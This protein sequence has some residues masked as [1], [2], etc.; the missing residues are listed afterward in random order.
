MSGLHALVTDSVI[1]ADTWGIPSK[2]FL[3]GYLVT[4]VIAI[5]AS[6]VL[7]RVYARSLARPNAQGAGLTA[8]E[9]GMLLDEK[10][11]VV[12]A[13]AVLRSADLI[14][15]TGHAT[16][17]LGSAD[18]HIDA[19]T[20]TVHDRIS[21]AGPQSVAAL[22]ASLTV[23]LAQ[24]RTSM[25]DRGL[26]VGPEYRQAM[27]MAAVPIAIVAVAGIARIVAGI[28]NG[29]SV[30][31]LIAIVVVLVLVGWLVS[32]SGRRTRRGIVEV[33]SAVG[34][35]RSS[36]SRSN[37]RL[38]PGLAAAVTGGAALWLLD[39]ALAGASGVSSS[40]SGGMWSSF[41]SGGDGG[42]S[43]SSDSGSGSSCGGGSSGCGGGGGGCG[44]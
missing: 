44:G 40:D 29:K 7:R 38:H 13:I 9:I 17:P 11:A 33:M 35:V 10:R 23:P 32:R 26:L 4:A 28:M 22:T 12:A 43:S 21:S 5:V 25:I 41:V 6:L 37:P 36:G 27:R 42:S 18:R 8:P 31:F 1:A 20:R 34:Q 3:R 39:P 19:F 14:D 24:L 16:R 2:Q 30:G 15:S